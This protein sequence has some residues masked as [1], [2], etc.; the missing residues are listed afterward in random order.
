MSLNEPFAGPPLRF[1]RFGG[2]YRRDDVELL[3]AEFRLTL[4]SLELELGA[5]RDRARELDGHLRDARAE[6]DAYHAKGYEIA[7]A[8]TSAR[9]RAEAVEQAAEERARQIVAQA[10][11]QAKRQVEERQ[12]E[13]E[14]L[15]FLKESLLESLRTVVNDVEEAIERAQHAEPVP[16]LEFAPPEPDDGLG[17]GTHVEPPGDNGHSSDAEAIFA[18]RVELD[19]GPFLDYDQV[20]AFEH[21]LAR[22]PNVDDVHVEALEGDRALIELT[23]TE[24]TPLVAEM[25]EHLPYA[26]RVRSANGS[27]L[28]L[29]VEPATHVDTA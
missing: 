12:R 6:I 28:V 9:R 26:L 10:E 19:A 20:S 25:R 13:L 22:I 1:R 2:G 5:L 11:A 3:L 14:R 7:R 8:M 18:M 29:D 27:R 21:E 15:A 4:R 24:R 23:M 16:E 17:E